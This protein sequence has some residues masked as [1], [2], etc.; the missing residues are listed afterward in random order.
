MKA[1]V[2]VNFGYVEFQCGQMCCV[3]GESKKDKYLLT[4]VTLIH[5][6]GDKQPLVL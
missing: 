3:L 1:T 2:L 5:Q 6:G 4:L